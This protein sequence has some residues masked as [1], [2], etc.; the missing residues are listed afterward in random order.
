MSATFTAA[1]GRAVVAADTADDIGEIKGFVVD[2]S[3]SRVEGVHIAGRGRRAEILPWS[4]IRSFGDDAVI[5][6]AADAADRAS[7]DREKE[8]ARGNIVLLGTRVLSTEGFELGTVDDAMF[9]PD[10]GDITGILTDAGHIGPERL[11]SLG[12]YA[13]VVDPE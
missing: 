10:S 3:A 9:D 7:D 13:L 4:S 1:E 8:A 2:T 6:E 11:R 5:A 12:S